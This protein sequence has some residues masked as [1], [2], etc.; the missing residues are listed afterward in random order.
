MTFL[1][2]SSFAP[3]SLP[4]LLF[5]LVN[6]PLVVLWPGLSQLLFESLAA[7]HDLDV[8][9]VVVVHVDCW[10]RTIL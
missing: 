3:L 5:S 7:L 8:V 2:F 4:P 1:A 6:L 10:R 9:V